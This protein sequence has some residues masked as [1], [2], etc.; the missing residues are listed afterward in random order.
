M[1]I[2]ILNCYRSSKINIKAS[3]KQ[4]SQIIQSFNLI[5]IE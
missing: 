1:K 5:L 4:M 3:T 2:E